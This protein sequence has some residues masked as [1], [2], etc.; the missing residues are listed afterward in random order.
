[1]MLQTNFSLYL[2]LAFIGG[3]IIGSTIGLYGMFLLFLAYAGYRYRQPIFEYADNLFDDYI[4]WEKI[5]TVL[6]LKPP[7]KWT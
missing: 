7:K 6:R 5:I 1:M 2:F 4:W 3:V